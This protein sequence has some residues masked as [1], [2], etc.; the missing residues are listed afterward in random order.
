[1][2]TYFRR[3]ILGKWIDPDYGKMEGYFGSLFLRDSYNFLGKDGIY[4]TLFPN[5]TGVNPK[6]SYSDIT[7]EKGYNF[8]YYIE[9]LIKE[10]KMQKFLQNFVQ[11]FK[12]KSIDFYDFQ[13]LFINFCKKE[14]L[15]YELAQIDW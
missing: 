4:T 1:M 9:A 15:D 2:A 8:L 6:D 11:R 14:K 7:V 10:E 5:L 13:N 3:K 12:Y